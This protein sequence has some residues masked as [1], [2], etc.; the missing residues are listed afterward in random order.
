MIYGF[1]YPLLYKTT[2]GHKYVCV[3][4]DGIMLYGECCVMSFA[5]CLKHKIGKAHPLLS[6]VCASTTVVANARYY[7]GLLYPMCNAVLL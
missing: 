5:E 7:D 1:G 3:C 6:V 4:M 2:R